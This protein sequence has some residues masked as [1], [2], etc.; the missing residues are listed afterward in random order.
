M[1][2]DNRG[3]VDLIREAFY[4]Q[5]RFDGTTMV[6]KID[7]PVTEDQ[8]FKYLMK[9]L[10]LLAQ[11]GIRIVIV[12]GAKEWIDAVL[13]E[14]DI[15]S[16]YEGS[17]RIT[18]EDAIPFVKMAAFEVATRYMTELSASRVDA[19]IGNFVRAR[20]IGVVNGRDFAHSGMVDKIQVESLKKL[21]DLGMVPILPCIGWSPAGK[22]YNLPSDEIALATCQALGAVKFFIVSNRPG[23]SPETCTIPESVML[24]SSN[25]LARL[26][27]Q[28][29]EEIIRL[30]PGKAEQPALKELALAIRALR[31]GVERVHIVN[32]REEGAVLRELFS[33][34]GVGTMVY[35]DEYESVR[36]LQ[37]SDVTE[38]LRLM[39]PLMEKGIL[40]QRNAE[41]ILEKKDDYVVY[42]VDG[43]VHACG[44]L[45]DWGEA[46]GEIAALATDP[47][48]ADL[49]LGRRI[50]GYLIERARKRSF[51]RVFVLTTRTHDWFEYLGFR[52]ISVEELP[53]KKRKVYNQER[54]SKV[55]ALDL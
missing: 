26:T 11:T 30:N 51:R 22:P 50:V 1:E 13:K 15:E 8:Q 18:T 40:I 27:P 48:Y 42:E 43:S 21:M 47:L 4:Y 37:A 6:F 32:S 12:P 44:A 14:Y 31:L 3:Q 19:V 20:G 23:I 34:L 29:A 52:E 16:A 7:F 46:Q 41:Q 54:R 36:P 49:G 39:G 2:T 17:V 10:A 24:G 53:E 25:R 55:F 45:H 33:N 5:S 35:A 28:E 38:V 9:D